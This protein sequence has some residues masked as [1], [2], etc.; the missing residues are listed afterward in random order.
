VEIQEKTWEQYYLTKLF[1]THWR[2]ANN[3]RNGNVA[4]IKFRFEKSFE[5]KKAE[6][7][8]RYKSPSGKAQHKRCVNSTLR[9]AGGKSLVV[10]II[11][12]I[13]VFRQCSCGNCV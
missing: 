5:N 6:F 3:L 2:A 11:N 12:S 13:A 10:G 1:S 7:L 8:D 9:Y 4:Q